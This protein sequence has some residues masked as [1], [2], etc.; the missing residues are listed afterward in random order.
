M[1]FALGYVARYSE[2]LLAFVSISVVGVFILLL[3]MLTAAND[4]FSVARL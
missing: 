3:I 2:V 4:L 1:M